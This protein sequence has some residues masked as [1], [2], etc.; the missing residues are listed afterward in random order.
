MKQTP[1]PDPAYS[2]VRRCGDSI[3]DQKPSINLIKVVDDRL[4][5]RIVHRGCGTHDLNVC[6]P[7]LRRQTP[8][9]IRLEV[10]YKATDAKC[11][12]YAE[13]ARDFELADLKQEYLRVFGRPGIVEIEVAGGGTTTL[14]LQ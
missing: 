13:E 4:V 10:S 5:V 14:V 1:A 3:G 2:S 6:Y 8:E 11:E 7:D 12:G 9:Y